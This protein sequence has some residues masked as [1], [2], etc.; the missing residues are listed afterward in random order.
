MGCESVC[1]ISGDELK[2]VFG[3]AASAEGCPG[4]LLTMG[5]RRMLILR[6]LACILFPVWAH[7]AVVELNEWNTKTQS[8]WAYSSV[9]GLPIVDPSPIG[10][11]SPSGGSSIRGSFSAGTYSS[12]VSGGTSAFTSVPVSVQNEIY[13]GHWIKYSNP[14]DWNPVANKFMVLTMRDPVQNGNVGN[15]RDNW[16]LSWAVNGTQLIMTTQLWNC[17][18]C[19]QNRYNNVGAVNIQRGVWYWIEFHSI[20]NTVG[21]NNGLVEVWIDDVLVLRHTDIPLRTSN[22]IMGQMAHVP[23]YGG[24]GGTINQLQHTWYDH[25]VIST[26][27]IG[28]P[29]SRAPGDTTAPRSPVLN[30]AN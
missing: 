3:P 8:G 4:P 26:T 10:G 1:R 22:T 28:R 25:S 5:V 2:I 11:G 6:V 14:F 13:V 7:A 16:V 27:R 15:G 20:L 18:P 23:L 9:E 17:P 29:A 21:Q 12:S 30:F 24:G 19:T